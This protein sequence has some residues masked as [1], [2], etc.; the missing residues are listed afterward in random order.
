MNIVTEIIG[1][2]F[3][4]GF[5]ILITLGSLLWFFQQTH[6]RQMQNLKESMIERFGSLTTTLERRL[7]EQSIQSNKDNTDMHRLMMQ[8]LT[9]HMNDTKND[10]MQTLSRHMDEMSLRLKEINQHVEKRLTEGFEKTTATF[11][12]IVKRLALIDD[13]QKKLTELSSNVV[14]LQE[15][16]VDKR[17]RG[18]FGEVQLQSL[19]TNVLPP[20]HFAFQ[21]SLSN[22]TR[23]DCMLFLPEPT[24]NVP[25]DSKFPLENFQILTDFKTSESERKTAQ[26]NFKADIKK[27]I[28][29]VSS[30]YILPGETSEGAILFIPAE[31][32]F[33]EIHAHFPELVELAHKKSVWL[34]SPTTMMAILTTAKAVLKDSAT[35]K[36]INIIQQHLRG[37]AEDFSRFETRM[38]NLTKHIDQAHRDV[39]QVHTSAK[40][41]T[42]R[43][44][45]IEKVEENL[46]E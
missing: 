39:Q 38:D 40:K 27:H 14:S 41:I 5:I 2:S 25:I 8:T 44:S 1:I 32:V 22:G 26:Q 31:A 21:H 9:Q 28:L 11:T 16:L 10:M 34:A 6:S 24:G 36:H 45:Q 18:A 17:S 7:G 33:A 42:S 4:I 19:I 23:V 37:L 12:D 35:K 3:L 29:D 15:I 43:F 30:K 20:N 46:L 13:A